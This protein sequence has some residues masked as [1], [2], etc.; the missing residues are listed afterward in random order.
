MLAYVNKVFFVGV[1]VENSGPSAVG[2]VHQLNPALCLTIGLC[3]L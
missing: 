2:D 3:G 1:A